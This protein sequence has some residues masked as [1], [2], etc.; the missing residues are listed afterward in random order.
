[1]ADPVSDPRRW[2]LV[3]EVFGGALERDPADWAAYL[4]R[5]CAGDHDLR[6]EVESLLEAHRL[7][8]NFLEEPGEAAALRA[9]PVD[10][11][12]RGQRLGAYEIER[13]IGRG[14]MGAVY[15]AVRAD[16]AFDKRVA[17]KLLRR[18]M[19][20]AEVARRFRDERQILA[21]L[22]HPNVA[23]LLDGGTTPG[24]RPYL[25]MEYVEGLP[26]DEYCN[27]RQLTVS[28]R[29]EL[30]RKVCAAVQFAHRNLVVHRD[31]KPSNILGTAAGEPKLLDF[32]IAKILDP[33]LVSPTVTISGLMTPDYASPEQ[34]LG[35]PA[36][37]AT[38]VWALGVLLY[39][40]LTGRHP[41]ELESRSPAEVL[42]AIHGE[43]PEAPSRVVGPRLR[44]RLAGDLDHIVLKAL[45]K[46]PERRYATVDQL[47]GD[48]H[49]HLTGRP[50][51]AGPDS[52]GYRCGK[53]FRRHR[54][55][56]LGA[57][58]FFLAVLAFAVAMTI[59]RTQIARERDRLD[60]QRQATETERL[61]AERVTLFLTELFEASDPLGSRADAGEVTARQL[62]DRGAERLAR[63]GAEPEA[64]ADL[65]HTIGVIYQRIGLAE[66]AKPLLDDSL[67]VRRSATTSDPAKLADSL[68]QQGLLSRDLGDYKA[69]EEYFRRSLAL[70][71]SRLGADHP[72]VADS[73]THLASLAETVGDFRDA[74]RLQREALEIYRL[75]LS[76]DDVKVASGLRQLAVIVQSQGDFEG[77]KRLYSETL[78]IQLRLFDDRHLQVARTR[79]SLAELALRRGDGEHA[80][81]LYRQALATMRETLGREHVE[82]AFC[83]HSLA[84]VLADR[85]DHAAAEDLYLEA[86]ALLEKLRGPEHPELAA[87]LNGL[88]QVL[89]AQGN[90]NGSERSYGRALEIR[91]KALGAASPYLVIPLTGLGR[92]ANEKGDYAG[93]EQWLNRALEIGRQAFPGGHWRIDVTRSVLGDCWT[94]A[95]RFSEAEPLLLE[96]YRALQKRQGERSPATL[97]TLDRL[98]RLYQA[99][100]R[101]EEAAQ[102]RS[103]RS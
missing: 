31:L 7:G 20:S 97:K 99:W 90:F 28:G 86:L 37:T 75:R 49:R 102:L 69:A 65:S 71:R 3:R 63:L 8:A 67:K 2:Q 32:G 64:R 6:S 88:G 82:V 47:S 95:E 89:L 60:Q 39:V 33:E 4:R 36:T 38:D 43:S 24:G 34:V 26:I 79:Y 42:W 1:M 58:A 84:L 22:E 16:S 81:A 53:L 17:I 83:L 35:R 101:P 13:C 18:G 98:V 55:A 93:A 10:E 50:I 52:L 73:L 48:L 92:V 41:L 72:A 94:R 29:L 9:A 56:F 27:A 103:E 5:A 46:E 66:K 76:D 68:D 19:D 85:G 25:V 30:L 61:R 57:A 15:S 77:A 100:G 59:Q 62:L 70:R 45:R 87:T 14:G 91:R 51:S 80:E 54:L 74:E 44:R 21:G 96:S 40:L 23:R 78:A 11:D 12:L